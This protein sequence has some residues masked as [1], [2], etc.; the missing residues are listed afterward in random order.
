MGD[1][2]ASRNKSVDIMTVL[3]KSLVSILQLIVTERRPSSSFGHSV[4]RN[5][6]RPSLVNRVLRVEI[7]RGRRLLA[8]NVGVVTAIGEC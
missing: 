7:R 3:L 8:R 4:R 1:V 6:R 2:V 5:K